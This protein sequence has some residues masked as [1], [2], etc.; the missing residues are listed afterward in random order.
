M[1]RRRQRIDVS[2]LQAPAPTQATSVVA[3]PSQAAAGVPVEVPVAAEAARPQ[4]PPPARGLVEYSDDSSSESDAEEPEA[5]QQEAQHTLA[6]FA[7]EC[8]SQLSSL[9]H[10]CVA[11][12]KEDVSSAAAA[13]SVE[14]AALAVDWLCQSAALVATLTCVTGACLHAG[15]GLL[16]ACPLCARRLLCR[17]SLEAAPSHRPRNGGRA[18]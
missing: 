17:W 9:L 18:P 1:S 10:I 2:A 4:S 15:F 8:A 3:E 5:A 13:G 16:A 12:F 11:A 14:Q 6:T 7:L